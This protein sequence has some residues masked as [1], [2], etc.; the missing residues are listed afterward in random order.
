MKYLLDTHAFLWLGMGEEAFLSE[1]LIKVFEDKSNEIFLHNVSLWEITIKSN[2]K[3]LKL[4]ISLND[5]VHSAVQN[6]IQVM[7][8][9]LAS[10]N[11]YEELPL[12]HRDPFDRLLIATAMSQDMTLL[13]RDTVMKDYENL[14]VLW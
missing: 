3:K 5:L 6:G 14:K 12:V 4:P 1:K 10:L 8:I 9:D 7:N 2:L 11:I 13:S